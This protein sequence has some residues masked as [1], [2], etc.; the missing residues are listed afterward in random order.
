MAQAGKPEL[1][2][3]GLVVAAIVCAVLFPRTVFLSSAVLLVFA[4]GLFPFLLRLLPKKTH[5]TDD[6]S[7]PEVAVIIPAHN[8]ETVIANRIEDL[9]KLSYPADR[10]SI[11]IGID[12]SDDATAAIVESYAAKDARIHM[13]EFPERQGKAAILKSLSAESREPILVFTDANTDFDPHALH[14]LTRHF[15]DS[16]VGGVCGRLIFTDDGKCDTDE[17]IYWSL[18]TSVK[19][20]E[21]DVDSCLGANGAVYAIRRELF[22]SEM[23]ANTIVDDFV[24]GMK[25][26]EQGFRMIYDPE[27]VAYEELPATVADE[28]GRR[29]RIGAGDFQAL[30]FCR[31]CLFPRYGWFAPFL[32]SHKVLRWT[33]SH[34]ALLSLATG[35][36]L[37]QPLCPCCAPPE[38]T[39]VDFWLSIGSAAWCTGLLMLAACYP[40]SRLAATSKLPG[41]TFV[42]KCAYFV[43]IQAA[44]AV[45]FVRFCRGNLSGAWNRT[46]RG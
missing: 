39:P 41:A 21:S 19:K 37:V 8:E 29:T 33:T 1:V 36:W 42:R 44:L 24:I 27:A 34:L 32:F 35:A 5:T 26:R 28:W 6:A 10:L 38:S 30:W 16:T 12:A 14:F 20:A 45:G 7:L 25:V 13:F 23:P 18:E 31:R 22:W 2:A 15:A 9:C 4:W 43:T 40:L 17:H 46:E 11:Y 3:V